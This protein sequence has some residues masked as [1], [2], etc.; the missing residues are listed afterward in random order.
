M[1]DLFSVFVSHISEDETL[2]LL[3]KEFT[4]HIFLNS[5]VFVSGRDLVGG[6]MWAKRIRDK[7]RTSEA[8]VTLITPLSINSPWV[9]FES[10]AGFVNNKTIPLL[11]GGLVFN[12]LP[13]PLQL[14]QA[15]AYDEEGLRRLLADIAKLADMRAPTKYPGI[16]NT[17]KSAQ[18]FLSFRKQALLSAAGTEVTKEI[19]TTGELS[20][21]LA[22]DAPDLELSKR[23]RMLTQRAR[24]AFAKAISDKE[25]VF[26]VPTED[27]LHRM[28]FSDLHQLCDFVDIPL[29][30]TT[31]ALLLIGFRS[32]GK[33]APTWKKMNAQKRLDSV[34]RWLD[35]FE[36]DV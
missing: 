34:E 29:H 15:R 24:K 2:A 6:E 7:L 9:I 26:D 13:A 31:A 20:H 10:G 12:D 18:E 21:I 23:A 1:A 5:E 16:N 33:N 36:R 32:P 22:R 27:E 35:S 28:S 4:E 25:S 30:K 19:P 14:L 8:I 3:L 11:A 17:I